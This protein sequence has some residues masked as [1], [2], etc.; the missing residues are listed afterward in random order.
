MSV[1]VACV[2]EVEAAYEAEPTPAREGW[3]GRSEAHD[4]LV[5]FAKRRAA[6]DV[7]MLEPLLVAEETGAH[8]L[9][10]L[11]SFQEY[12]ARLFGWGGRQTRERLRV[13][14]AVRKLPLIRARWAKGELTYS[15]VRELTRVATPEVESEWLTWA[16]GSDVGGSVRRTAREVQRIVAMRG[17]GSKPSDAP[18][19]HGERQVR[20][21]LEV[22]GNEA[23]RFA[24]ARVV[25][26]RRLGHAVDDETFAKMLFDAF[27]RGD[28]VD[29]DAPRGA[30]QANGGVA[31]NQVRLTVCERCGETEREAGA[32]GLVPVEKSAGEIARCD[33]QILRD[34]KRA[35][36]TVPPAT[37]REVVGRD[38]GKCRVPGCRHAAFV[39]VHHVDRR[40][41]GGGHDPTNLVSLCSVHHAAAHEGHLV[42]RKADEPG[43]EP[44]RFERADGLPYGSVATTDELDRC[45]SVVEAFGDALERTGH[46][47]R[48]RQS[49]DRQVRLLRHATGHDD[50]PEPSEEPSGL[51]ETNEANETDPA[52]EPAPVSGPSELAHVSHRPRP[53]VSRQL[54]HRIVGILHRMG[55]SKRVS[56]ALVEA[57]IEGNELP[58]DRP[59]SAV[60]LLR[61]ALRCG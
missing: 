54:G 43:E 13:A 11:G 24:E 56:A 33:A 57:A 20:I 30:G 3:F 25:A 35:K 50:V 22:S 42:I 8:E 29:G 1:A 45:S 15:V 6:D 2:R 44:F 28:S 36:Q 46:A 38:E 58:T 34:G 14:R 49:A 61:A 39:E 27:L 10:G 51:D 17:R 16:T 21:A 52:S 12:C 59:P 37:R 55:Y 5:T 60:E 9:I 47:G 18:L 53:L 48:A 26:A 4:R 19:P 40:A 31:P 23:A 32:E 41:D 7:A